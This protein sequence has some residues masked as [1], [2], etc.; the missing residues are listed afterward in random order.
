MRF[1]PQ[2]AGVATERFRYFALI[3]SPLQVAKSNAWAMALFIEPSLYVVAHV[4]QDGLVNLTHC[5]P[6]VHTA[7]NAAL[8][9]LR[10]NRKQ[11]IQPVHSVV[12]GVK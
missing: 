12:Q 11:L 8:L 1:V 2:P 6:P 10:D 3:C 5:L 9:Q 7:L 4:V